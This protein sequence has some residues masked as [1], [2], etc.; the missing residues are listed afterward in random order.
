M[1]RLYIAIKDDLLAR[2]ED[3]T[4]PV[5]TIIPTEL[6]LA[7]IYDVSRPT[8]RQAVQLLVDD[9]YLEKRRR[10]GTIVLERGDRTA[11][12]EVSDP[13]SVPREAAA[14]AAGV[15]REAY[16]QGAD[17]R[18]VRT[19]GLLTKEESA[20]AEVAAALQIAEG[21]AVY[22]IVRLRYMDGVPNVF[23]VSYVPVAHYP[24]LGETDFSHERLYRRMAELGPAVV[25]ATRRFETARADPTIATI[26]DVPAGDPL[27]L[28]NITGFDGTGTPQEFSITVYRGRDN[29]FEF[30]TSLTLGMG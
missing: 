13:A 18:H 3:G 12:P 29:A 23:M 27:F 10:R 28:F 11:R 21:D 15:I 22:K 6:E 1:E 17:A 20:S 19:V 14:S 8:I 9:G 5:G 4:Y 2:I 25:R 7:E 16:V 24:G 26:F 30:T